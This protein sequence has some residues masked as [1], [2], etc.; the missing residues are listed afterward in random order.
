M[1]SC[2]AAFIAC[3][4]EETECTDNQIPSL[5]CIFNYETRKSPD[6]AIFYAYGLP[7]S[8]YIGQKMPGYLNVP[9]NPFADSTWLLMVLGNDSNDI[10]TFTKDCILISYT[11]NMQLINLECGYLYSF[12]QVWI[13]HTNIAIDS[14]HILSNEINQEQIDH[15]EIFF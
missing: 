15:V 12:N 4:K 6:T 10:W 13:K 14:I 11:P 7:D 8:I 5:R 2:I 9:L 1:L 3:N